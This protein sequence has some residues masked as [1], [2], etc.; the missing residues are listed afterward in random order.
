M[1]LERSPGRLAYLA[2]ITVCLVWGT[3]YLGITVA[4]ETVPVLLVAGLRWMAAGVVMSALMLATGRGLPR[5]AMWGPLLLLGFLMNVVGNGFVVWAQQYVASG[6]T[7]VLIATTPFWSALVERLLPNGERFSRRALVGLGLGF[8]G[9]VVL[10][11]PEMTNGGAGGRAFV[12]GVIAIQLACVGWVIG[13]SFAKRHELGDNPFRSTALQMVFSGT[14]LLT[15]ATINGDWQHLSFT[16]R[17]IA[18]MA[19][20]SIAGSLLA[21]S[22]YIYA[23]QHLPL[24]LVSLYAYI[25]PIIAVGLGTLLLAEPL[26]PRVLVAAGL[27]LAGTAI[28]GKRS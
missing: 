13:T 8:T 11:W 18:A 7:A 15:A 1:N 24:S 12:L 10:V 20:L 21:Y 5:P 16:P 3:T 26:T 25:N 28:V 19:Y 6:L 23:I 2:F 17:T 22:A 4:L 9:I 27:V 14:M